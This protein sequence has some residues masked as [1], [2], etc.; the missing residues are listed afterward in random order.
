LLYRNILW[1]KVGRPRRNAYPQEPGRTTMVS[2]ELRYLHKSI[3]TKLT[4]IVTDRELS[5]VIEEKEDKEDEVTSGLATYSNSESTVL[6]CASI[7]ENLWAQST[8]QVN[9]KEPTYR[10]KTYEKTT[11]GIHNE[12]N[13]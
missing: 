11:S 1:K 3:Q 12:D 5:L 10:I 9:N 6:S 13:S 7:F 8:N 4:T 2:R